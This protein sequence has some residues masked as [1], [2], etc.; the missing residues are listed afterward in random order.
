MPGLLLILTEAGGERFAAAVELAATV[1][2]MGRPVAALLRGPAARTLGDDPGRFHLL[3]ELGAQ[4]S[5][6]QTAMA[7]HGLSAA[8]LPANVEPLGMVAFLQG[9]QDWQLVV[10]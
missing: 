7:A 6:C 2:A 10:V 5:V 4:V 3:F 9:R 8:G 1:A